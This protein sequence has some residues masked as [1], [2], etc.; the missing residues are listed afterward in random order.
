MRSTGLVTRILAVLGALTLVAAAAAVVAGLAV[1]RRGLSAREQ[2][3]AME[4][5]VARAA[6]RLSTPGRV[7]ALTNPVRLT[8]EARHGAMLHWADHC[9]T[10][11][12]N[13]GSGDTPIG[14]NLYPRAPDI[15]LA[16][17]QNLTDGELYAIIEN[18]IRLTGMP[19]WGTGEVS[20]EESWALVHFIRQLPKLTPAELDHM[21]QMNPR[22]PHEMEEERQENEFLQ[23]NEPAHGARNPAQR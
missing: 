2:P 17:T 15:R 1:V 21:Q 22:S 11:H 7:R 9:A 8:P 5:L 14:K 3:S 10:C 6:R 12:A 4:E 13:N 16:E 19:A 20:N 18:G 23:G